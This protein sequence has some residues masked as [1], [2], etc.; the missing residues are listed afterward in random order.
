LHTFAEAAAYIHHLTMSL[1]SIQS[2][3]VPTAYIREYPRAT[4]DSQEDEL[5]LAVKQYTPLDNKSP[6]DGDVT[7]IG[8]HANGFP[9]VGLDTTPWTR[10]KSQS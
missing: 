6:K 10:V 3:K 5:H 8:A 2:H 7:I 9:K 1:F 4:A